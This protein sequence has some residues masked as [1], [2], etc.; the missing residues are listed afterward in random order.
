MFDM[1][2]VPAFLKNIAPTIATA[3][4][5]PLAGMGLEFLSEAVFGDKNKS[6]EELF[7]ALGKLTP[8]QVAAIKQ[9][10]RE[11]A[12]ELAKQKVK[13]SEL[14]IQDRISARNR[15]VSMN[16]KAVTWLG[17][18]ILLATF[19]M[20]GYVMINGIPSEVSEIVAGR[21]LGTFDMLSGTVVAYFFG[22]SMGSRIKDLDRLEKGE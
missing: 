9:K 13:L 17:F 21:I 3:L 4:G 6:P 11:F 10:D 15:Q 20:E 19:I 22:S 8:A 12:L 5:G 1:S 2:N 18:F 14:E 16:D 7:E